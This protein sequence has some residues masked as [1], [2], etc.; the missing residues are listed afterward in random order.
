[1]FEKYYAHSL[2]GKPPSEWQLLEEHLKNVAEMTAEFTDCFGAPE[3]GSILGRNHDLGK[4]TRHWQAYL[5]RANNI[6][7]EFVK[8]YDG[9]PTHATVGA[10]WLYKHSAEA[11]KLLAYCIA[12]HHGGLPNWEGSV[13]SSLEAAL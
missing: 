8:F 7:D 11:G 9:H 12:G 4:G 5:R 10:Q 3:W 1:M 6:V 13:T 2:E